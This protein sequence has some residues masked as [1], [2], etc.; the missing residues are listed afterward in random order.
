[1]HLTGAAQ[2]EVMAKRILVPLDHETEHELILPL[3]GD[4][5]RGSGATVRLLHVAPVPENVVTEKGRVVAYSDQEMSRLE[6]E[7]LASLQVSEPL[8]VGVTV[9]RAVR[10]GNVADEIVHEIQTF[11]ADLVI[12]TTT[13][14]SSVK[15]GLLGS[16]AEQVMR[17]VKPPVLLLRP[18]LG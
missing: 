8:F 4:L 2:E 3:V 12:V 9:E 7:W 16:V 11:E 13:C 6:H 15:R 14:R 1:L 10:F 5:A 18:A 17:R